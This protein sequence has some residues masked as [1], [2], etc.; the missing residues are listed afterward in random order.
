LLKEQ[1]L[2]AES[3]LTRAEE[4]FADFAKLEVERNILM[5]KLEELE[6]TCVKKELLQP[7][8][9][10]VGFFIRDLTGLRQKVFTFT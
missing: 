1:L 2:S 5:S 6:A 8:Q 7:L 9:C 3:K 4:K 10:Q